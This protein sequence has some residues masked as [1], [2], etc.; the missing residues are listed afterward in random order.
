MLETQEKQHYEHLKRLEVL[1]KD[2]LEIRLQRIKTLD[3]II[4]ELQRS[5]CESTNQRSRIPTS[6]RTTAFS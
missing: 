2:L 3:A 6:F 5:H 4:T 1:L